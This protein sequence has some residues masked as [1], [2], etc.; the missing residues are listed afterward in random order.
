MCPPWHEEEPYKA[1]ST[2]SIGLQLDSIF[3]MLLPHSTHVVIMRVW[4]YYPPPGYSWFSPEWLTKWGQSDFFFFLEN[5]KRCSKEA[6]LSLLTKIRC[7][8]INTPNSASH[9]GDKVFQ[10][11]KTTT[12]R[13]QKQRW[14]CIVT[15]R[16]LVLSSHRSNKKKFLILLKHICLLE[17]VTFKPILL[18]ILHLLPNM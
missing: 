11:G 15:F 4:S 9:D 12:K 1:S 17:N 6:S 7:L 10:E 14:K 2:K 5:F 16:S 13:M 18:H 3:A 8:V